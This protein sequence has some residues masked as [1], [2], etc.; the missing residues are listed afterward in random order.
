MNGNYIKLPRSILD[1]EWWDDVNTA[2]LYITMMAKANFNDNKW[3]GQLIKRGSFVTSYAS[4]SEL[5]GLTVQQVRTSIKK[6][7]KTGEITKVTNTKNTLIIVTN[8]DLWQ[9][10]QQTNNKQITN[11]QQTNNKQITTNKN[12][13]NEK[14]DKNEKN[15]KDIYLSEQLEIAPTDVVL[16]LDMKTGDNFPVY[17]QDVKGWQMTYPSVD[18]VCELRKMKA[19][20]EAN[21]NRRKTRTGMKRFINGWLSREQDKKDEQKGDFAF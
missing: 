12:D 15:I 5:T 8:Y 14:N 13:N 6:L 21:P 11:N 20:L 4:L 16:D 3:R 18:V 1:W 17:E 10:E 9:G 2:H 7:E 19:W